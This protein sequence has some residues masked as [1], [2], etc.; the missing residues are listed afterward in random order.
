[1]YI[2]DS[3]LKFEY[4]KSSGPGGQRKNKKE[5][6]VRII[7]RSTGL[8]AIATESR[9]QAQNKEIARRRLEERLKSFLKK[10][11]KRVPTSIS[12]ALK[13]VILKKKKIRAKKKDLRRKGINYILEQYG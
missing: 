7:H 5:T 3:D 8:S 1:M 6:A 11:K 2:K 10:P 13:E 9:F 12:P 4:Y